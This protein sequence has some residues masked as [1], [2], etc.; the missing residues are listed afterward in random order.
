M[1]FWVNTV[2]Y[3]KIIFFYEACSRITLDSCSSSCIYIYCTRSDWPRNHDFLINIGV[4]KGKQKTIACIKKLLLNLPLQHGIWTWIN[5]STTSEGMYDKYLIVVFI[6]VNFR[7]LFNVY[8]FF[9][10]ILKSYWNIFQN[11]F[12]LY[13]VV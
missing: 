5:V 6:R 7:C 11:L 3:F 10:C 1:N 12:F 2:L 13:S 8:S 9:F 4:E